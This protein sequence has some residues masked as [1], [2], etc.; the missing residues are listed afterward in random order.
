MAD[1]VQLRDM[2]CDPRFRKILVSDAKSALGQAVVKACVAAG[3]DIVWAGQAEPWKR[4]PGMD[5]LDALPQVSW[6]PLD[7]SDERSVNELAGIVGGKVDIVINTADFHR[8]YGISG[9]RGTDVAR[10]EMDIN[11]FGLLRLA[12]AFGPALKGRAADGQSHACAWVECAV[13][14]RAEQFS[15]ARHLLGLQ[16]GSLVIVAVPARRDE[17]RG[18][19][20]DQCI[21]GAGG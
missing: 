14:L 15:G 13:H 7:L 16:G 10:A 21:S 20:R 9:R 12:Q 17:P 3:A 11:Y 4:Y 1:D 18:H 19:S 5:E 6:V 2:T 8:T